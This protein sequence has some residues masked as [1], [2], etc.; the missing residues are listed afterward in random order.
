MQGEKADSLLRSVREIA[1]VLQGGLAT[2]LPSSSEFLI[3]YL[4]HGAAGFAVFLAYAYATGTVANARESA[5]KYLEIAIN[6]VVQEPMGPSLYSGFTGIAWAAEHV[7]DLLGES[8]DDLN[9]EVDSVVKDYV[10]K[11]PWIHD[12]DLINGLV[13]LGVYGLERRKSSS[14]DLAL[15]MIVERFYEL[16]EHTEDGVRWFTSPDLFTEEQKASV[17]EGYYNLGLAHGIPGIIALLAKIFAAGIARDKAGWLLERAV[18]WLLQ[19]RLP[20]GG[21]SCFPTFLRRNKALSDSRLAWCYGDAGLATAVLLAA[22]KVGVRAWENQA[23]AILKRAAVRPPQTSGVK[24]ACFC[25]GSAG[26]AHIFNRV[27]QA[28]QDELFATASR[29]WIDRTRDYRRP[30]KGA[31]GYSMLAAAPRGGVELQGTLNI[32]EGI[33]GIGLTLVAATTGLVPAWDRIFLVDVP[34]SA[35]ALP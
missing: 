21:N 6:K 3:P 31:A 29:Y 22:R 2:D 30:G 23:L 8:A 18:P 14:A 11:S 19:Q 13:G 34:L 20:A 17:P 32:L 28:T 7:A 10:S 24:D 1:A 35:A 12:F 16:A 25:H 27:F 5:L 15:E 33:A 9:A 4:G 26:L